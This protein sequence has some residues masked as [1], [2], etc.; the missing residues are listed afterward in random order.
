MIARQISSDPRLQRY[1]YYVD[2]NDLLPFWYVSDWVDY[3]IGAGLGDDVTINIGDDFWFWDV[4]PFVQA[5]RLDEE[6]QPAVAFCQVF[7]PAMEY[8]M[9]VNN[10]PAWGSFVDAFGATYPKTQSD[11]QLGEGYI[12]E[13]GGYVTI[14]W[15][16]IV[17]ID[18]TRYQDPMRIQWALV[19]CKLEPKGSATTNYGWR[20][21]T[22]G[23]WASTAVTRPYRYSERVDG[24]ALAEANGEVRIDLRTRDKDF[25]VQRILCAQYGNTTT[26]ETTGFPYLVG[27]HPFSLRFEAQD[28]PW[29]NPSNGGV[30]I[31]AWNRFILQQGF[32]P[33]S[34]DNFVPR[35]I[36]A[37]STI[38]ARAGYPQFASP[39]L[40][41]QFGDVVLLVDGAEII[42]DNRSRHQIER[43]LRSE[44]MG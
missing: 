1:A 6:P 8:R 24:A 39:V 19:G 10:N 15:N 16:N 22:M 9:L 20:N 17:G 27:G 32:P 2:R 34:R 14:E 43:K 4:I 18:D 3:P 25:I 36:R 37:N 31:Y 23:D 38:V 35:M 44:A 28:V 41:D 11:H 7:Y 5:G 29:H 26:V 40:E 42:G 33:S 13:R 21:Q 12:V 30:N